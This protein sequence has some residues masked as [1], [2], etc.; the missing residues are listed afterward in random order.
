MA[1]RST[2]VWCCDCKVGYIHNVASSNL[3]IR[4]IRSV[5]DRAPKTLSLFRYSPTLSDSEN[6]EGGG[7]SNLSACGSL[8][9]LR[10]NIVTC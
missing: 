1:R 10:W 6:P 2:Q 7:H 4:A 8:H 9:Y 5:Q 3:M